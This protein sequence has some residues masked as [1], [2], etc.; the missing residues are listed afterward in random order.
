MLTLWGSDEVFKSKYLLETPGYYTTGDAGMIDERGYVHIMTRVDDV[1]NTS[2]HRISTGQLEEAIN[3]TPGVVES[4]VVGYNEELHGE[5]PIAFVVLK[6]SS[7]D[8]YSDADIHRIKQQANEKVRH[9]VGAFAR[10]YGVIVMQKL[11]KTRSG[12]I[13]RGTIK[14]IINNMEWKMPATIEDPHTLED[15]QTEFQKFRA[16][17]H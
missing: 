8:A 9:D 17:L 14:K 11:P 6:G 3:E 16:T 15:I 12:K 2:G 13:V 5:V 1:I 10:L 4:A 7:I